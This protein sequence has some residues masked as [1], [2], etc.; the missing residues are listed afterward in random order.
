MTGFET[1]I[2]TVFMLQDETPCTFNH[3]RLFQIGRFI[4]R[5]Q[6]QKLLSMHLSASIVIPG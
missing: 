2:E 6:L 1:A 5:K 4:A 3:R